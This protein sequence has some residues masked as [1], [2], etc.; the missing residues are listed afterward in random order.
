MCGVGFRRVVA[1]IGRAVCRC[2]VRG[3]GTQGQR[4]SAGIVLPEH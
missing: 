4:Q 2:Y 3:A 1:I